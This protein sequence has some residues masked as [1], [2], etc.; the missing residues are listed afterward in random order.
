MVYY[1]DDE[2][3]TEEEQKN[4]INTI[5]WLL[6]KYPRVKLNGVGDFRAYN[7][8][9]KEEEREGIRYASFF[10]P[11]N[12]I[13]INYEEVREYIYG[14]G[15]KG[16]IIHEFAHAIDY[17]GKCIWLNKISNDYRIEIKYNEYLESLK[18]EKMYFKSQAEKSVSEYF[19]ESFLYYYNNQSDL[20]LGSEEVVDIVN[21]NYYGLTGYK[22]QSEG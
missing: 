8:M 15:V 17:M 22:K 21:S 3:I 18:S 14:R 13:L 7:K 1:F 10:Y 2:F 16:I 9:V 20:L 4:T 19:A 11:K 12:I 5:E 6:K